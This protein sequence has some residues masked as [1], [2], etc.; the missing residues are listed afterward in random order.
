MTLLGSPRKENTGPGIKACRFCSATARQG[1]AEQ[2]SKSR[3]KFL[4]TTYQPFFTSLYICGAA[5]LA[6]SSHG[7]RA[8][9]GDTAEEI[10]D[11]RSGALNLCAL[12]HERGESRRGRRGAQMAR[13][14]RESNST[15][16]RLRSRVGRGRVRRSA[17]LTKED[18]MLHKFNHEV[19]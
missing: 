11:S 2:L 16:L 19:K 1:Q 4:A 9:F 7:I 8:R 17:W 12:L 18:Q 3:K 5:F 13:V 14:A 6:R 10:S 15:L